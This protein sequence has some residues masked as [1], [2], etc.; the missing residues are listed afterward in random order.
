MR[1]KCRGVKLAMERAVELETSPFGKHIKFSPIRRYD[2][3]K[4]L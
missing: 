3:E 2:F 1:Q 4:F